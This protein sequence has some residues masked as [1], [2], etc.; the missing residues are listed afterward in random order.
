QRVGARPAI[1]MRAGEVARVRQPDAE[2]ESTRTLRGGCVLD[3]G[4]TS[5][6]L[7]EPIPPLR[8]RTRIGFEKKSRPLQALRGACSGS[9]PGGCCAA[10]MENVLVTGGAGFIGS[11]LVDALVNRGDRVRVLD[12]LLPQAHP[13]GRPA[14]L[15]REAELLV[16]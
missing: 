11:H 1:A 14:Y 15:A 4:H 6:D 5:P 13:G 9:P 8:Q 16:A 7:R 2:R 3:F 12:D 10:G